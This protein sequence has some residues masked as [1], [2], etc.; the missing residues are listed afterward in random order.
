MWDRDRGDKKPPP[1][2]HCPVTGEE[3]WDTTDESDPGND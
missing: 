2:W 3:D 1:Y